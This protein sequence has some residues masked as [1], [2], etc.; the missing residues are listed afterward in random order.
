ME[1]PE[2]SKLADSADPVVTKQLPLIQKIIHDETWLE[3]ERRGGPVSPKDAVV[4]EKV[5]E[6]V[7]RT[8]QQLREVAAKEGGQKPDAR[9]QTPGEGGQLPSSFV[10]PDGPTKDLSSSVSQEAGEGDEG[11]KPEMT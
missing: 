9:G 5:C 1:T 3:G 8:G 10:P 2:Q 6:V 7:L 11:D 4:Q